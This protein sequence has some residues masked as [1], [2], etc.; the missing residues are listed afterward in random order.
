MTPTRD[1]LARLQGWLRQHTDLGEARINAVSGD[2][3]FRR[4]FRASVDGRSYILMDAPPAR[5]DCGPF[6]R[7]TRTLEAAGLQVP[8]IHQT[9]LDQGILLLSDLGDELYLRHLS[10]Q[11][12]DALYADAF[13]SLRRIQGIDPSG[14]PPYDSSLLRREMD[15][16]RDWFLARHLDITLTEADQEVLARG[17]D[18]LIQVAGEQ[19]VVFV[20][21]DYHSRNLLVTPAPS[22]GIL[23]YQDAV[24]GPIT[25]DLVSLL[26]DA[27]IAWPRQQVLGW[28]HR[29]R[30]RAVAEG[31]LAGVDQATWVRWFE[32]MG[33]QR[34]LKVCG[35]FARLYHRDDKP[36][37]LGDIPRTFGYIMDAAA[38]HSET[39]ALHAL[40]RG[41]RIE[42]RLLS[43]PSR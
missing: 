7:I 21:R 11:R 34:Q 6:I 30:E 31:I 20:H 29:Y 36:G 28:L 42:Q 9:D 23:D 15:L 25:Y 1:D 37:Y 43:T 13:S 10:A 17:F 26:R 18:A 38:R 3:S 32:L 4:Y 5:E 22:P 41:L 39:A 35:I 33:V 8:H 27:Y 16:F 24:A 14:L 12:A 2:A 40:L 19:P